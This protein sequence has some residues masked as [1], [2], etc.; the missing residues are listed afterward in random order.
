[1]T[2][3]SLYHMVRLH[4]LSELC[5]LPTPLALS[6]YS[7]STLHTM[8]FCVS[9]TLLASASVMC[10]ISCVVRGG[11][12]R[13]RGCIVIVFR[14]HIVFV[15]RGFFA[16]LAYMAFVLS[17][18]SHCLSISG[19]PVFLFLFWVIFGQKLGKLYAPY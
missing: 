9:C 3:D 5:G 19:F 8:G 17:P 11:F 16:S 6:R 12:Y 7:S 4:L 18:S 15:V 2:G 1:M 13:I 10:C 14:G